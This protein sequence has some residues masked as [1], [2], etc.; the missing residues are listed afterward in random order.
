[1]V[2]WFGGYN[3][4]K[5]VIFLRWS[6]ALAIIA[7]AAILFYILAHT[8][9]GISQSHFLEDGIWVE[10]GAGRVVVEDGKVLFQVITRYDLS[11]LMIKGVVI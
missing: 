7:R 10:M 2:K 6:V 5:V 9:S 4:V 3:R 11:T 1:M 8:F